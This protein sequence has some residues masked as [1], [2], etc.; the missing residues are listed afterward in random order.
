[1]Y[2]GKVRYARGMCPNAERA[3][4]EMITLP[5]NEF[6]TKDDVEDIAGAIIKVADHYRRVT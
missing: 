3:L 1:M 6:F 4:G 2:K 5:C